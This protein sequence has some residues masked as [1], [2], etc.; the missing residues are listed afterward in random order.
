MSDEY[1]ADRAAER[2]AR[3][4]EWLMLKE[5]RD[6]GLELFG[7]LDASRAA[8]YEKLNEVAIT[9]CAIDR[10]LGNDDP[11]GNKKKSDSDRNQEATGD[12]RKKPTI[13][14][15]N[16]WLRWVTEHHNFEHVQLS[17]ED[18]APLSGGV[19]E[20]LQT[21][22]AGFEL[23][24]LRYSFPAIPKTPKDKV[25]PLT[26]DQKI[27]NGFFIRECKRLW[28]RAKDELRE[29]LLEAITRAEMKKKESDQKTGTVRSLGDQEHASA[30]FQIAVER[31]TLHALSLVRL[32]GWVEE[33]E[34]KALTKTKEKA[35]EKAKDA[36]QAH[37]Q[38]VKH[39][40]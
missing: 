39:K 36:K 21:I 23:A 33:D 5:L 9:M 20:N 34:D 17:A 14:M 31:S 8:D 4:K 22:G 29:R 16:S 37:E 24:S 28:R 27:Q 19:K 18:V 15:K 32:K 6:K 35:S 25:K 38:F 3:Y 11:S 13:T 40:D 2:D 1:E 10:L 7:K 12:E 26:N 30:R